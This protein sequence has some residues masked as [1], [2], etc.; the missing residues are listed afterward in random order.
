MR[1]SQIVFFLFFSFIH[2]SQAQFVINE[3]L[4][5]N[6][7]GLV[8]EDNE[9]TD[10]IELYNMG[11]DAVDLADYA[12]TDDL[13]I[14]GKWIFP[15]MELGA[16]EH[17]LVFASGKDRKELALTY[18]T[19]IDMGDT[20]Q[21]LLPAT[22]PGTAWRTTG[23][24][25]SGWDSG[26]GG[27]GYGDG[28]DNTIIG[29]TNSV[30]IRREFEITDLASVEKLL[31]NID[32][33]DGFI[34]FING[35][36]IARNNLGAGPVGFD[37]PTNELQREATLYQGGGTEI[38]GISDPA[39]ILVEG[40]NV[41]AVQGHNASLTSSDL[42]LIPFLTLGR[43]GAGHMPVN[44]E[45][46]NF[47][48]GGLHTNFKI[49]SSGESLYLF[50]ISGIVADSVTATLVYSDISYGRQPDGDP[51]WY[52]F[53]EPTPGENNSTTGTNTL[54]VDTVIFSQTGGVYSGNV[55]VGLATN[56]PAAQ[57]YY[58]L[59]GSIPS[60]DDNLFTSN[61]LL[62]NNTVVRAMAIA[63]GSL[64]GPVITNTYITELTHD[65]P[66][67]CISTPPEN[68]WDELT[69]LYAMGPAPG[70]YPYFGANFWQDWEKPVHLEIYDTQ[71]VKQ[72]DQGAGM[73]IFGGW[74]RANDQ[75]SVSLFARSQYGKGSFNYKIFREKSIEKFEAF[76]LRNSGNDNMNLQFH[77]GFMTG[78][79]GGMDIEKQAFEPA[80]VYLNGVYWGILNLREKVNEHFIAS[81]RQVDADSVNIL[82]GN[83]SV[84]HGR[85][86]EYVEI[87]N[88]LE[89]NST[90][91]DDSRYTWMEEHIDIDNFIR[92]E[93]TEIYI[94][95]QD[96]P[97][98]NIKFW[99]TAAAGSR[100][101]WILFDTDFGY[102]IWGDN[103]YQINTL[104]FALAPN[105]PD[106]PNPPWSTLLLRRLVTN[107]EFRNSFIN[108]YCDRLNTDF[109]PET[110][111]HHLDSLQTY[112]SGEIQNHFARWWGDYNNWLDQIDA[113]RT[114]A[115]QRPTYSRM[116]LRSEFG[117]GNELTVNIDI[118]DNAAGKVKL[119][120][121]T[122]EIYPFSGIYFTDVPVT[123]TAIPN[124]GY[125][126][127]RWEGSINS[128]SKTIAYDMHTSGSFHAVFAEAGAEDISIVIN[129]INYN[130]SP[131]R[132]TKDW[133]ELYNNGLTS[134]DLKD[135]LLSDSYG[136][137]G[138]YFPSG[139]LLAPGEYL[140]VCRDLKDFSSFN[141]AVL[142]TAGNIPFGL[143][144]QGDI[145]RLYDNKGNLMDA[146]D[147]FI[148][149]PWPEGANGTGATLELIS[150]ELDNMKGE[151]WQAITHGGTPGRANTGVMSI[152]ITNEVRITAGLAAFPNPF[153]DY[154]TIHF[155][156]VPE[157]VYKLEV[158]DIN[159]RMI[160]ILAE[161]FLAPGKY[162]IDWYAN[163]L[164]NTIPEGFYTLRLTGGNRV[165]TLKLI[166]L[167]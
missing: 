146:V 37:Q 73:K 2:S 99:N 111:I 17:I 128:A 55:S 24:D 108:Q 69:G 8:D 90:L 117:L 140:V 85:N 14:P 7:N 76:V 25:A 39:G 57:I 123:L 119:N 160:N 84:I 59:D 155:S 19:I 109:Q 157:G 70:D 26:P 114:F 134:L 120:S 159:G 23:Y 36:E 153:R 107:P 144:S 165:E 161:E 12:L 105:G 152:G 163:G 110:V 15:A 13:L 139:T 18:Q 125:K 130:S 79:T 74:S 88:Y 6:V 92:Y 48:V 147:Y 121:I 122:P 4:P 41:I 86:W 93:L 10:W 100:F 141:P 143:S 94:N 136:D 58:T 103:D 145:L 101:R 30:F 66:V 95:N 47:P 156:I 131:E 64:P 35:T 43:S 33:D 40:T 67:V 96:W 49:S 3:F 133:V 87:L 77:D 113:K 132:D 149:L 44:S 166:K 34:A 65:F 78:L 46:L 164:G 115:E 83:G 148:N 150:P 138:H 129:E 27:F 51:Q 38:W 97:G 32:Y 21:Y 60:G 162:Y 151:N 62:T 167:K 29:T 45:Y 127:V 72:I 124:P 104:D 112:F 98:N 54:S 126:F 142:N 91:Q 11:T 158:F 22:D 53:G 118:S 68:L 9:Y 116:H 28:D 71:G 52:Y 106:W 16:G 75:K 102:G 42:S 61:L 154:T 63:E 1:I 80:V 50:H 20:W 5:A 89:T 31:F 56:N 81:N 82:E 137:T 135:W